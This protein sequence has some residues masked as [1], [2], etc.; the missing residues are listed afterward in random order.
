MNSSGNKRWIYIVQIIYISLSAVAI[1]RHEPWFDEAQAWLIARDSG[2]Y[3]M[4]FKYMRYEGSPGLW[5]T[6]LMIPARMHMPYISLNVLSGLIAAASA[7]IFMRFSP[8]PLFIKLMYP[9]SFF[10]FYQYAI[11]ARSYILLPLFLFL[12]AMS[13]KDKEMHQVRYMLLL[14]LLANISL[15]GFIIASALF[16]I[17]ISDLGK[18]LKA[19]SKTDMLRH[20][21]SSVLF[22][23]TAVFII[24]QLKSPPDLLSF[25]ASKPEIKDL[26][27]LTITMFSDSLATNLMASPVNSGILYIVT[28]SFACFTIVVSL[29][30]FSLRGRLTIFLLPMTGLCLLFTLV[31]AN[32]WHQ[33]ILFYLWLFVMWLSF[34]NSGSIRI[35]FTRLTG[36]VII[37]CLAG[38]LSV[39]AYW[40][41]RSFSYD[42]SS[43]YSG[44]RELAS[45]IKANHLES[46]RIYINNFYPI[47]VLPYFSENLF[48][49]YHDRQKPCFWLWSSKNNMY[50]EPFHLYKSYNPDYII[51]S[52]KFSINTAESKNRILPEIPGYKLVRIFAGN[53]FW[54]D[55][56]F[57]SDSYAFFEKA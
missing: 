54:K 57:E 23:M 31:Y 33:G 44:S 25:A 48:C 24:F 1:A 13:Y 46:K 6:L 2:F 17:H 35:P 5:H 37:I 40:S 38:V 32:L 11:I 55:G 10:A 42:C 4:M 15:H 34:E 56:I 29:I 52:I 28:R 14:C 45:Y 39:Q 51:Y 49:N 47:A 3:S 20:L 7:F 36:R 8:L 16:L 30:W 50:L 22:C 21:L 43:S 27:T 41:Y 26:Y 12:I 9:F 19:T 53:L 18:R